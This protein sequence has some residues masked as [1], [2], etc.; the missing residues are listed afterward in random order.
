MSETPRLLVAVITGG[1]PRLADRPTAR[2]FDELGKHG[3]ADVEW[4]LR[5]DHVDAYETDERP[6]NVYPLDWANGYAKAHWRHPVTRFEP[7][8]F[9][10]AFTGREWAMR[11]AEERGYDAVLLLD[12]NVKAL[13][14]INSSIPSCRAAMSPGRML[15]ILADLCLSTNARMCGAQLNSV[16]PTKV[17]ILRPGY[18]YSVYV[19]KTGPGRIPY[20]GPFEDDIMHALD[21]AL[22]GGPNRTAAVVEAFRYEKTSRRTNT[23]G[24][25]KHYTDGRGL[26]IARRYPNNVRLKVTRGTSSPR[27]KTR[28]VRH[29]LNTRGFTPV[30][31]VDHDL[32]REAADQVR[33]ATL[34]A[35]AGKRASDRDKMRKRGAPA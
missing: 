1:R 17:R 20:F 35:V 12:D 22:D 26:E 10:G 4:V 3:Y 30:R 8:G 21:Y 19:E 24:M 32:Y 29:V 31:V 6:L 14:P 33:R 28:G 7:D 11:T 16:P 27:D 2:L 9:H 5:E 25:R 13:G 15:R 18:P 23:G 34:D